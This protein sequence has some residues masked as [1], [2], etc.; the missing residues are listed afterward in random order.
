[1][2]D[3][4]H[5]QNRPDG[6]PLR[7]DSSMTLMP[8]VSIAPGAAGRLGSASSVVVHA[9]HPPRSGPPAAARSV[10]PSASATTT[11]SSGSIPASSTPRSRSRS[12]ARP[13]P[14]HILAPRSPRG[15]STSRARPRRSGVATRPRR[16][17][18]SA[19]RGARRR[20]PRR[21]WGPARGRAPAAGRPAVGEVDEARDRPA[22]R[23]RSG[24]GGRG[25]ARRGR[26]PSRRAA[27]RWRWSAPPSC[28]PRPRRCGSVHHRVEARALVEMGAA[29]E[30]EGGNPAHVVRRGRCRDALR[31]PARRSPGSSVIGNDATGSPNAAAAGAQ[32]EPSTTTA[33][34][35]GTPVSSARRS[36]AERAGSSSSTASTLSRPG[37][38][39]FGRREWRWSALASA[40]HGP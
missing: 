10:R 17:S 28:S 23:S 34:C 24:S 18:R 7:S 16:A 9:V 3:A 13:A 20:P 37:S 32:P 39:R 22:A 11:T 38:G 15:P 25:R 33:R 5:G 40:R 12:R 36:A 2:L 21:A 8:L 27:T 1:M 14:S 19:A 4:H 29:E 6:V 30:H 26:T 31:R 35:L